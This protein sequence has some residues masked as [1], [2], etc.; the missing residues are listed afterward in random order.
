[1]VTQINRMLEADVPFEWS[2][3]SF[4]DGPCNPAN[5]AQLPSGKYSLAIGQG[6]RDLAAVQASHARECLNTFDCNISD[7]AKSELIA[8]RTALYEAFADSGFVL[9]A[10]T[11]QP[12]G[13]Q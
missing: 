3:V 1:M 4:T 13:P 2:Q 11:E 12:V 10:Q 9:P 8:V 7:Q 6:C 5:L